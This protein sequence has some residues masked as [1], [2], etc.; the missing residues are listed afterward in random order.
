MESLGEIL[1]TDLKRFLTTEALSDEEYLNFKLDCELKRV[2]TLNAEDNYNC[3]ICLNRGYIPK[4]YDGDIVYDR[5]KCMKVRKSIRILKASGLE[6]SI[7]KLSD[8]QITEK[9]QADIKTR[10]YEFIVDNE[11]SCFYLGGQT[12]AGKTHICSG[13]AREYIKQGYDTRYI[14]WVD[15]IERMKDY[16]DSGRERY[17]EDINAA[18]VLYIDDFFKPDK[19][20]PS[21]NR[22]D[23]INTF[24]VI[25]K[26][27]KA[28]DKITLISSELLIRE[29]SAVDEATAGRIIEMS[30]G[31]YGI[32]IPKNEGR[33]YRLRAV[34]NCE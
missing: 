5:C 23:I 17:I 18:K 8:F 11:A 10:A 20:N 21:Y 26:R 27:Y 33:N 1:P 25:D 15:M 4:I 9:W 31:I 13:I 30:K 16:R 2:G 28:N 24:K 19:N 7:K 32:D 29:L 34:R 14:M 6:G 12:G 22:T 3:D